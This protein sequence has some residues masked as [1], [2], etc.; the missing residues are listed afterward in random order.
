M[1]PRVSIRPAAPGDRDC[2]VEIGRTT[3]YETFVGTCS[4]HD[5]DKFLRESFAPDKIRA[6]LEAAGSYFYLLVDREG[7]AQGYARLFRDLEPDAALP[8][9]YRTNSMELVRFYLRPALFGTGAG[10]LL[11]EHCLAEARR[12]GVETIYLG[13][14]EKNFRAQRFY[15]KNGFRKLAEK[16]FMVGDDAQTDWYLGR[17]VSPEV[18]Q[19]SSSETNSAMTA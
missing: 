2:L 15:G 16:I 11:M 6:E 1:P 5:M 14:W 3:F 19:A 18:N 7:E 10:Q 8:P 13:V 17:R 4:S 9:E 12:F